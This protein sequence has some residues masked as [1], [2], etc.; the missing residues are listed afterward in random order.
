M[1]FGFFPLLLNLESGFVYPE[2][3]IQT[4]KNRSP[5]LQFSHCSW[6]P[7]DSIW[8]KSTLHGLKLKHAI[9]HCEILPF[10]YISRL[11]FKAV[12]FDDTRINANNRNKLQATEKNAIEMQTTRHFRCPHHKIR[13]I[14]L[15]L[16]CYY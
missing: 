13:Q 7:N 5:F 10:F 8:R 14:I 6:E 4:H 1:G 3:E 12:Y 11:S 16:W 2:I 15:N 9:K